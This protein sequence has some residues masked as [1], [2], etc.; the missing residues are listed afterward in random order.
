[1]SNRLQHRCV[2]PNFTSFVVSIMRNIY[3]Q[4]D[5]ALIW[6]GDEIAFSKQ[7]FELIPRLTKFWQTREVARLQAGE[8]RPPLRLTPSKAEESSMQLQ[9]SLVWESLFSLLSSTY[10]KRTWVIQ[11]NVVTTRAAV[12]CGRHQV[13]WKLFHWGASFI[14]A[15]TSLLHR[16]ENVR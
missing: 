9:D 12:V 2:R 1:M 16:C 14:G 6:I 15:T 8:R 3:T 4:A 13:V 7:A 11:E 5:K 10:F